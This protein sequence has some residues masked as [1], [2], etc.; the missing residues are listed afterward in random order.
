MHKSDDYNL[1]VPW[2]GDGLLISHGKKWFR[3]RKAI[4]PAFHFK[5]LEQFVDVFNRQTNIFIKI[6]ENYG[7]NSFDIYPHVSHCALDIICG[8]YLLNFVC[9]FFA[10]INL[11]LF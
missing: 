9:F 10:V 11:Y 7:S 1:L 5:I 6:L 3:R 2:L 4:T 8:N